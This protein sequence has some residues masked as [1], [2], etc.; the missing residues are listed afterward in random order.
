MRI[1][2]F[3]KPLRNCEKGEICR[4]AVG[5]FIP[6][7][8]SRNARVRERAHRIRGSCRAVFRILVVVKEDAVPLFFPPFGSGK[9][10]YTPFDLAREC[11][12]GTAYLYKRPAWFDPYID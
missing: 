10:W 1:A 5:H 8:R 12:R 3:C 4:I 7:E 11:K 9:G 2:D 6:E